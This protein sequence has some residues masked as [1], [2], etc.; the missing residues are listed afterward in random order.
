MDVISLK[1]RGEILGLLNSEKPE[2]EMHFGVCSMALFGTC[3]HGEQQAGSEVD[4]HIP[5]S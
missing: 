4:I 1:T 2:L 3:G 5:R